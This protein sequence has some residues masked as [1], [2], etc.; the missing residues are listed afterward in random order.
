MGYTLTE[1]FQTGTL[2][3]RTPI[4]PV[5]FQPMAHSHHMNERQLLPS[6][7]WFPSV[8]QIYMVHSLVSLDHHL[9]ISTPFPSYTRHFPSACL[10][11]V[12]VDLPLVVDELPCSTPQ[13][14]HNEQAQLH[15]KGH[16]TT[17][18]FHSVESRHL[19]DNNASSVEI[20]T[21]APCDSD[22]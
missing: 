2:L 16:T 13:I 15:T 11:S 7:T 5:L 20:T 21:L 19:Y 17:F 14:D 1:P 18:C 3:Q 8:D 4:S 6:G 22:S 10:P 9:K 12:R